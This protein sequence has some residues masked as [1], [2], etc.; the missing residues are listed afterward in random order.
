MTHFLSFQIVIMDCS[1]C[2]DEITKET[3]A[4]TLSC[5][6]SFHLRC[7]T[8]WFWNQCMNDLPE[9]CPCCRSNGGEKDRCFFEDIEEDGDEQEEEEQEEEVPVSQNDFDLASMILDGE[10]RM[11]RLESDQWVI[12]PASSI[13]L[14]SLRALFG[15]LNELE[16]EE[17][18]PWQEFY[19]RFA[20]RCPISDSEIRN[21]IQNLIEI[22]E[23]HS[24]ELVRIIV[25]QSSN[26]DAYKRYKQ[27]FETIRQEKAYDTL[28]E[29]FASLNE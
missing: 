2:F 21:S 16:V 12:Q 18:N 20:E 19:K 22:E 24:D 3:G 1:I 17:K 23:C 8:K 10:W 15:P 14:D 27:H 9:N 29:M 28:R 4:T 7:I 25:R 13:A 26:T 6:H 5:E 11:E